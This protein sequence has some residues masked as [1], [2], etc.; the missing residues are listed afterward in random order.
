MGSLFSYYFSGSLCNVAQCP[1]LLSLCPFISFSLTVCFSPTKQVVV[2]A[3]AVSQ[4]VQLLSSE[5]MN[6]QEQAVWA[7][8]NIAGDGAPMRDLVI[9]CGAVKPLLA[10]VQDYMSRAAAAAAA[11]GD[12]N[13]LSF[14]RNVTWCL[15]NL[16]R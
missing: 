4:F 9:E 11:G 14:L 6:V 7:L 5:H 3:G 13:L 8:G 12:P 2:D 16:C 1:P 10:L 15:S